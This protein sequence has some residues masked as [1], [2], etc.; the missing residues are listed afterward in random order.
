M[1]KDVSFF[2]VFHLL[3]ASEVGQ[4]VFCASHKKM[5]R[6]SQFL[7]KSV[8]RSDLCNLFIKAG[9]VLEPSLR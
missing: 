4:H 5:K 7:L 1:T 9:L 6:I 3:K 2:D 8:K